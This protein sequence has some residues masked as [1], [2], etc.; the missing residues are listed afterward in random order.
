MSLE[1]LIGMAAAGG[2]LTMALV[3]YFAFA[4]QLAMRSRVKRRINF[5]SGKTGP[6]VAKN[7]EQ[8]GGRKRDIQTRLKEVEQAKG[9][10]VSR[11]VQYRRDLRQAGLKVSLKHFFIFCI[12]FGIVAAIG[13]LLAGYP[14]IGALPVAITVGFGLP[15]FVVKFRAGRRVKK[16]TLLFANAVDVIVRGIKSGLPVGEC[17]AIIARESPE[18]VNIVFNEIVEANKLGLDTE[19]CIERAL[20]LMPTTEL[21]FF[22]IVMVIQQQ[23][24]GNLADTLTNLSNVL[25]ARKKMSD[26][27]RALSSEARSS[28]MIIGSLPFLMTLMLWLVNSEYM[29]LLFTNDLGHIMIL[30]GLAWMSIGVLVMRQ[31]INFQI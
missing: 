6:L 5:A 7:E 23:T 22:G 29:N 13:Y 20:E 28:A 8:R 25:R 4:P 26:K 11:T 21:K 31:M 12:V 2:L 14:P 19:Q 24:G 27:V 18:P 15:R 9:Q 30:G 1:L 10:T 3:G 17:L 16:F